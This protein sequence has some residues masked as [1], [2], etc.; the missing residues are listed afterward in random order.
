M[1]KLLTVV[2]PVYN[3]EKYIAQCLES[4]LIP[5]I[6]DNLEIL[7][8]DDGS[9]DQSAS[10]VRTYADSYPNSIKLISKENGG[11]G[12]AINAGIQA[13]SGK[14][15][16][17]VDGDDW[18]DKKALQ[19]MVDFL[20]KN[21]CDL[22]YTHFCWVYEG[23]GEIRYEQKMPFSSVEYGKIYSFKEIAPKTF[24]KMHNMTIRT[25]LLKANFRA[26]D[27]KSFY[28]DNEYILYPI[29]YINSVSFLD[30][31]VYMYRIGRSE[32]SINI[33]K[34]QER[35]HQH[36]QVLQNL[37]T[38]Y[39]EQK[40]HISEEADDYLAKGIAR[41]FCSQVKIY[42]SYPSKK[43]HQNSI[44][45]WDQQ[46]KNMYPKVYFSAKNK[47]VL[48]LRMSNYSLYWTASF[49]FRFLHR[50]ENKS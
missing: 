10:I 26:I 16:K 42:L 13:A 49:L 15:F 5:A 18:V 44:K 32:Q 33:K 45:K 21:D 20:K 43:Q 36:E 24:I 7:V 6:L 48:L 25:E 11:H 9:P 22:L 47:G 31:T 46:L 39:K 8:I 3:V 34:M 30:E 38:F 37:L 14:Y 29:P 19:H 41:M 1:A 50:L 35:C 2:I 17:I 12:S 27:E 28:V 23:T 4:F 40:G